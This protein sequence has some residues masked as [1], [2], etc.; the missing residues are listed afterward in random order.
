MDYKYSLAVEGNNQNLEACCKLVETN[1]E[2]N[3]RLGVE[4]AA[5]K[6]GPT[7]SNKSGAQVDSAVA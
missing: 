3:S 5:G 2:G 4:R 6:W 1:V 7:K